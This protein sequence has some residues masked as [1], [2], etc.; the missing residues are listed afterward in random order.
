MTSSIPPASRIPCI[1]QLTIAK[2]RGIQNLVWK[3]SQGMNI[4]LGGGDTGKTTI[5]DAI[6][7]LLNPTNNYP[8]AYS[9]YYN[10]L[11][12]AE[13]FIEAVME[14]PP[15]IM[16]QQAQMNWV[17]L[18]DG[19]SATTPQGIDSEDD[20][21]RDALVTVYKVRVTGTCD[22]ELV[23]EV[24]QPNGESTSFT[25][26]VRQSVGVLRLSAFDQHDQD[27]RLVR[28]SNLERLLADTTLRSRLGKK[29]SED[30]I[31]GSL[32]DSAKETLAE[33]DSTFKANSLPTDLGL[34]IAGSAGASL[35]A[36]IGLT[37]RKDEIRLPLTTWG[38]GTRRL[39]ILTISRAL[40]K[41]MPITIVD[42]IERGLEPYRQRKIMHDLRESGGQVFVTTHSA[43]ALAAGADAGLWYMDPSENIGFLPSRSVMPAV[44]RDP[45]LLLSRLT[46][47]CEGQTEVGFVNELLARAFEIEDYRDLGI[48]LSD[49]NGHEHTLGL[50]EA[51]ASGGV[52]FGGFVDDEGKFSGRWSNLR[53]RL[54]NLLFQ[55]QGASIEQYLIPLFPE[56]KLISL[57]VDPDDL[58]TGARRYSLA[59]RLS[60][61]SDDLNDIQNQAGDQ[62]MS[63][64]C[65]AASGVVPDRIADNDAGEYRGHAKSWFKSERGGRELARK[66]FELGVWPKVRPH[67][68]P[69]VNEI[70]QSV[71]QTTIDDVRL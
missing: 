23:Y 58:Q 41:R 66:V 33:L 29:L 30:N 57:I 5:L 52:A 2:F 3:P 9:D 38:T 35:N 62:F 63:S 25:T 53:N 37:A 51:L 39:A 21:G 64:I 24:I 8:I 65:Q 69:F 15:P 7:L 48:W 16:S 54:G 32:V 70:R 50:L 46:I 31:A 6:A 22:L 20:V 18:W 28:W 43:V 4:I 1:R 26:G 47:V 19:E 17:W 60:I 34:G 12:T 68:M 13:F 27:L 55:W 42:E 61:Q 11:I 40:Q 14:I 36:M 59:K 71:G 67:L 10:G 49:G 44:R 56:D 45:H